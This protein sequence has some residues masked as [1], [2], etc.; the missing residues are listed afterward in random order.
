MSISRVLASLLASVAGV[1][2]T[3]SAS[4]G[5]AGPLVPRAID[6][7]PGFEASTI[8]L[9]ITDRGEVLGFGENPHGQRRYFLDVP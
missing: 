2:S 7:L 3:P 4:L 5:E 1:V 9:R 8:A 6:T